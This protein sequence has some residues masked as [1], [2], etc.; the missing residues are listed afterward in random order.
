M[1]SGATGT[2]TCA[3]AGETN[4]PAIRPASKITA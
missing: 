1:Q 2:G 3:I 4:A